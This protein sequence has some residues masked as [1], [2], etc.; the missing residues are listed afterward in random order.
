MK[1]AVVAPGPLKDL[2]ELL[3][4]VYLAADA[5]TLDDIAAD[6]ADDQAL[7]GAPSRDTVH[8]CLS[9]ADLPPKQADAVAV[10]V[11]LAR[12]AA[13]DPDDLEMRVRSLW[14][15]ARTARPVGLPIREV[16]DPFALEVHRAIEVAA[17]EGTQ[18]S[19]L[20]AYVERSH[21]VQ[22]RQMVVEAIDGRSQIVVL[23][24]DS[25]S[26]KTR[27]CWEAV[28]KIPDEWRLWHPIDPSRPDAALENI[29][30][31][32]RQTVIWLNELQ[33]YLLTPPGDLGE[34]IAAALRAL[35]PDRAR[36][37]VL[38]LATIWPEHWA[39]L[40]T[41]PEQSQVADPHSQARAL[42]TGNDIPVASRFM[43]SELEPLAKAASVD[44]RVDY[45]MRH[46]EQGQVTQY[47]AGAPAL[48]ERYVNA[49]SAARAVISAAMDIRRLGHEV[50]IPYSLIEDS[51]EGYLTDQQWDQLPDN[52][53][54]DALSYATQSIR[55]ARGPL[56]R[57]R[58]RRGE[59][60]PSEPSYRLADYLDQYGR[61][62]R[63]DGDLPVGLWESL[64]VH[65]DAVS[66]VRLAEAAVERRFFRTAVAFYRKAAVGGNR[67]ALSL[68]AGTLWS[69]GRQYDAI[70]WYREAVAAGEWRAVNEA[71]NLLWR[72]GA[73]FVA[74]EWLEEAST[75][76]DTPVPLAYAG[77][78]LWR[79][80][81]VDAAIEWY[82]KAAV[83][84]DFQSAKFLDCV[85]EEP[86]RV[87]ESLEILRGRA[88]AGDVSALSLAGKLL[89]EEGR[90]GDALGYYMRAVQEGDVGAI[91][92][93]IRL[94]FSN[95]EWLK[96]YTNYE[97]DE[98][99][100][101]EEMWWGSVAPEDASRFLR[102]DP[103]EPNDWESPDYGLEPDGR[104]SGVWDAEPPV[105]Q[106]G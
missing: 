93:L 11:V 92:C 52:W 19:L 94:G 40:V 37:P 103:R 70:A 98:L 83:N 35:M 4:E 65:A 41:V 16:T 58:P 75:G 6:I 5:P 33:H 80:G 15:Q 91:D 74:L 95:H 54:E 77:D 49:P 90:T 81:D 104:Y 10:A 25:S 106:H 38:I 9:S 72:K 1:Q 78:L 97:D 30:S 85:K 34:R 59:P 63:G 99:Y 8:R 39:T 86:S 79:D 68:A 45:A 7:T 3:Y 88:D 14:V 84:G 100:S 26:G 67:E 102:A 20:P 53:L 21:D 66:C 96:R 18:L 89:E 60:R 2:K 12:R 73:R 48:L 31:V 76:A 105:I 51:A 13:W 42:L 32:G 43:E 27:A 29:A 47:L 24:G 17:Q 64:L 36:S 23:V 69:C 101:R 22:L 71:A 56:S 61:E 44:P 87:D 57:I 46:A 55:G 62:A 28:Q 82:Q 50:S